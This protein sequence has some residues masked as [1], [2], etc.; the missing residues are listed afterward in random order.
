[1]DPVAE[2]MIAGEYQQKV[3][4]DGET[5]R[6][7]C[8]AVPGTPLTMARWQVRRER[9]DATEMLFPIDANSGLAAPTFTF[10]A[11]NLETVAGYDYD[12]PVED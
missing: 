12:L 9:I 4:S 2:K 3:Y 6:Y 8:L 11:T 10:A 1:M 7:R 5:Y